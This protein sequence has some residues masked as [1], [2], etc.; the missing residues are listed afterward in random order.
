MSNE[1]FR[2]LGVRPEIVHAL[3]AR[4]ITTPF[5][6]QRLVLADALAGLDVLAKSPTGSGKTL[7]F[8]LALVER[9]GPGGKT[10]SALVLVP[11]R[12]LAAQVAGELTAPARAAGLRIAAVYGG[13]PLARQAKQAAA[14]EIL[15]ATPGRLKDL[16][17]RRLVSLA[18][19]R[20][21]V[22][23]E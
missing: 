11:T 1:S 9:A 5:P 8:G 12:E 13:K 14:A 20:I 17:D 7:A 19:V 3:A 22:L 10:P 18:G 4:A 6:I 2:S 23:D 21:L 15:I 16:I